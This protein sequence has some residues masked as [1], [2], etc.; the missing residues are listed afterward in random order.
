MPVGSVF[1]SPTIAWS[2][3]SISMILDDF[4]RTRVIWITEHRRSVVPRVI[5]LGGRVACPG[6][7]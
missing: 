5:R 1:A 4:P 7:H 2:S 3:R 6:G